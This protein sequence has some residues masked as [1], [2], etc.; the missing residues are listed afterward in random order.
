MVSM[1]IKVGFTPGEIAS[2]MSKSFSTISSI[3]SRLY[4][5][6]FSEGDSAFKNWDEFINSL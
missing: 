3:R 1:L 6:Y 2:V 5:K 4:K